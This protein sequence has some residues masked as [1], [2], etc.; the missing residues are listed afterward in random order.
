MA[1]EDISKSYLWNGS[2][3]TFPSNWWNDILMDYLHFDITTSDLEQKYRTTL[4]NASKTNN[5]S[6]NMYISVLLNRLLLLGA[7]GSLK[8]DNYKDC[9][10]AIN[11]YVSQLLNEAGKR[12]K[13]TKKWKEQIERW[14]NYILKESDFSFDKNQIKNAP[15]FIK[16]TM[17]KIREVNYKFN[18][19]KTEYLN[20]HSDDNDKVIKEVGKI[21]EDIIHKILINQ[22]GIDNVILTRSFDKYAAY[23]FEVTSGKQKI[24]IEVKS[25]K[26]RN[27]INWYISRREMEFYKK[28]KDNYILYFVKNVYIPSKITKDDFAFIEKIKSP[29]ILIDENHFGIH[30]NTFIVTPIKYKGLA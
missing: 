13:I 19:I 10:A 17:S 28:N 1:F 2:R 14:N 12:Y 27:N 3:N 22:H 18:D 11:S 4:K 25:S 23:D 29:N 15:V 5:K 30:S 26:K 24:Y 7:K 9:K 16:N 21:G 6:N 20:N 8:K